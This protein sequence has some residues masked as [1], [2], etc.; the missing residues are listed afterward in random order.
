MKAYGSTNAVAFRKKVRKERSK[1]GC[2]G[3]LYL[4]GALALAVL[5]FF[6]VLNIGGNELWVVTFFSPI[7]EAIGGTLD[8]IGIIVSALYLWIMLAAV[9]NFFKA[10]SKISWLTKKSLKYV[11]GYNRNIS[12]MEDIGKRFSGSFATIINLSFLIA[13]LQP[14]TSDVTITIYAYIIIAVGLLIHFLAGLIEGKVSGFEAPVNGGDVEENKRE[15]GIFVYFFRNIMQ[16]LAVAGMLYFFVPKCTVGAT[17]QGL[18]NGANLF[19]GDIVTTLVPVVLQVLI[20]PC[21]FVLIKHATAATEFNRD[22][23]KGKGMKNYRVFAFFVFLLASGVFAVDFLL[24]QPN[25]LVYDFVFVA[26]IAFLVFL[27]DCIFKTRVKEEEEEEEVDPCEMKKEPMMPPM[28][29]C[30]RQRCMQQGMS[31]PMGGQPNM[32]YPKMPM[33]QPAYQQQPVYIPIYYPYPMQ[34]PAPAPAPA[35]V[36]VKITSMPAPAPASEKVP[37]KAPENLKPEPSPKEKAKQ[38]MDDKE[39]EIPVEVYE[40]FDPN[41]E[42][43][44]RCPRCGKMLSVHE[45]SPYHRC[46]LCDKVF[47]LRKFK[48]YLKKD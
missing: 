44:V 5:A 16:L 42:W 17:L 19:E 43:K 29:F 37:E 34:Q 30:N 11:N 32:G 39:I 35:P 12:A 40:A 15:C 41:K 21:M 31:M 26:V 47:S 10:L 33:N 48:T 13:I 36:E 25:P 20:V 45:T 18:L 23:I 22:G 2:A 27:V 7:I 24:I 6:P 3:V 4:L 8:W 9:I 28:P 46:P 1:A 14:N 38:E